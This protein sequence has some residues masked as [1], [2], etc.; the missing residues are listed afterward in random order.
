MP[1][2]LNALEPGF[3]AEIRGLDLSQPIAAT[4][5]TALLAAWRRHDVIVFRNQS[6]TPDAQLAFARRFGHLDLAPKFDT[7]RS[8]LD[9]YP[10]LAVVSN[11]RR[12]GVP[13][14]GLGSGELAWHSDMTYVA[15]PPVACLLAVKD[16]PTRGGQTWFLSQRELYRALDPAQ[17]TRLEGRKLLHD[18]TYTSAGTLRTGAAAGEGTWHPLVVDDPVSGEQTLFLGRRSGAR[19]DDGAPEGLFDEIWSLAEQGPFVLK[20]AWRPDDVAL[21]NN[22]TV[23]HRRDPFPAEESRTLY[24]A[25]VRRLHDTTLAQF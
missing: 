22:V 25:Q 17:R 18:R 5:W 9:G 15:D 20:L 13:I 10:E 24:R 7:E 2:E 1:F 11:V 16:L 19:L 23:M 6:L 3:G 12:N 14:G 21:W 8:D 4:D